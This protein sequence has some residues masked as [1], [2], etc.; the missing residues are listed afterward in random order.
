MLKLWQHISTL[1]MIPIIIVLI[2]SLLIIFSAHVKYIVLTFKKISSL[3]INSRRPKTRRL[4]ME[5][6]LL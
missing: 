2:M 3:F 4:L 6:L 5:E 1:H